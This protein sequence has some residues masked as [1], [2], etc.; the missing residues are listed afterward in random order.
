MQDLKKLIEDAW[1][2]R[3]LLEYKEYVDVV[4]AN[5]LLELLLYK[6]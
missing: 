4:R 6:L 5:K 3:K 2:D 1:E